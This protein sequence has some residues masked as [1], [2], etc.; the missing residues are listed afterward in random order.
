MIRKKKK[1]NTN[2]NKTKELRASLLKLQGT[3]ST[4]SIWVIAPQAV[5]AS[6][7]V[8]KA[9]STFGQLIR[10]E[11]EDGWASSS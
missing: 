6:C 3:I 10:A 5:H 9:V 1:K 7:D 11:S 2:K 4:E 8:R